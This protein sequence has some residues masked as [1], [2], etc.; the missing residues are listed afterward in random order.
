MPVLEMKSRFM[1]PRTFQRSG[2]EALEHWQ[3]GS[4]TGRDFA[5]ATSGGTRPTSGR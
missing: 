4:G 3:W 5:V 2:M 1:V